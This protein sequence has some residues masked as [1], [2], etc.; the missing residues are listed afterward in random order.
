MS[1]DFVA[2]LQRPNRDLIAIDPAARA[3]IE[4]GVAHALNRAP[5]TRRSRTMHW[6]AGSTAALLLGALGVKYGPSLFDQAGAAMQ[7]RVDLTTYEI[8]RSMEQAKRRVLPF[9]P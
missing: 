7:E 2:R 1:D 3:E 6:V 9:A 8:S 5:Y 4:R